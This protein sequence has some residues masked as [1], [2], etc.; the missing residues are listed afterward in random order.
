MH[1]F[2][3]RGFI[4]WGLTAAILIKT[5]EVALGR[6]AAFE[7]E[8]AKGVSYHDM[9]FDGAKV[10]VRDTEPGGQGSTA[11]SDEQHA[12]PVSTLN[13]NASP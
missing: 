5:A 13:Q 11:E 6:P 10:C 8:A 3:Y 7:V 2:D 9:W 1:S 12:V 4:I